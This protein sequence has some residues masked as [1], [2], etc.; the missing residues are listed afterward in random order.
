MRCVRQWMYYALTMAF[1]E[2]ATSACATPQEGVVFS[3]RT[4]TDLGVYGKD[5]ARERDRQG[6][7][8][9]NDIFL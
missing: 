3:R 9:L 6:N 1:E 8:S 5:E 4:D 7:E 2:E